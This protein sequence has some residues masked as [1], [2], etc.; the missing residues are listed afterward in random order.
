[1]ASGPPTHQS[2]NG[3]ASPTSVAGSLPFAPEICRPTLRNMYENYPLLWGTYGFKDAFNPG[4]LRAPWYDTDFLG[5]DQGPIVLMIENFTGNNIW[6]RFM[7]IPAIQNGLSRAG[8]LPSGA[9]TAADPP[10]PVLALA[11]LA[12]QPS[13]IQGRGTIRFRIPVA[14]ARRLRLLLYDAR[15]RRERLLLDD[16]R[17]AGEQSIA[18]DASGLAQG[19]YLARLETAA[20]SVSQKYVVLDR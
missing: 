6:N 12:S 13:P 3:T 20:G 4:H 10:K 17:P 14:G 5:I 18:L 16:E 19:V 8:F 2:E 1:P 11:L 15:G 7:Q 9:V